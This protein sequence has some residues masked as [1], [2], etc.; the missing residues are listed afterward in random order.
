MKETWRL[1][2]FPLSK[3]EWHEEVDLH[4]ILWKV[5]FFIAI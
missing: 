2:M 1:A 5:D 3:I 4:R